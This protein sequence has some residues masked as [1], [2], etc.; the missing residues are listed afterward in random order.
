MAH[1]LRSFNVD[2]CFWKQNPQVGVISPFAEFKAEDKSRGKKKSSQVMWAI[3]MLNDPTPHNKLYR[4]K[5]EIRKAQIID[6][7]LEGK[8]FDFSKHENLSAGYLNQLL[9]KKQRRYAYVWVK[10][11]ER[12]DFIM[13]LKY[14]FDTAD[15]IDKLSANTEKILITLTRAEADMIK[16]QE[17]EG[18]AGKAKKSSIESI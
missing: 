17:E 18:L 6:N 3:F 8:T 11:E 15:F 14:S 9:S 4:M 13:S 1:M 2:E 5:Q 7:Y 16:E 12:E 10:W